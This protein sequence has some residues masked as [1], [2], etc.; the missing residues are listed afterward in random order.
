MNQYLKIAVVN[1]SGNVGKTTVVDSLLKPRLPEAH[2]LKLETINND[3]SEDKTM[4]SANLIAVQEEIDMHDLLIIDVGASNIEKWLQNLEKNSGSHEDIDYYIVPVT[5]QSKQQIDTISTIKM[6]KNIGVD[7]DAIRVIF[8]QVDDTES[9]DSQF[10]VIFENRIAKELK[11]K[12]VNGLTIPHSPLFE[13]MNDLGTTLADFVDDDTDYKAAIRA[14]SKE[15]RAELSAR[16]TGVR[17]AKN[18]NEKLD[19][20]YANLKIEAQ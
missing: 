17:L 3:G 9:L 5:P 11:L 6:L 7:T 20:V 1:T 16:R 15:E 19:H 8:N 10:G 4:S 14:A 13:L 18:F 2:V 12:S